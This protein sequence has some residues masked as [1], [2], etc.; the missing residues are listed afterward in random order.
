VITSL[1]TGQQKNSNLI[2]VGRGVRGRKKEIKRKNASGDH[3]S[4]APQFVG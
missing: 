3:D 1:K 2:P 4:W